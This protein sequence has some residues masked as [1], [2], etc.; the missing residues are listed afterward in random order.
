MCG[1]AE[2]LPGARPR[3]CLD[4]TTR[5]FEFTAT[6]RKLT[7]ALLPYQVTL[8]RSLHPVAML[9][10]AV[11]PALDWRAAAWSPPII[12]GLLRRTLAGSRA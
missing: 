9:S 2:A 8:R 7:R 5:S 3:H 6:Q 4:A 1:R 10:T 11:Y 12:H